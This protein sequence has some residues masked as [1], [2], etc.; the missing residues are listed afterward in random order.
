[1]RFLLEQNVVG[2]GEV[3]N[4]P[5][6]ASIIGNSSF[7]NIKDNHSCLIL[8][9][10]LF[11]TVFDIHDK[12]LGPFSHVNFFFRDW[13]VYHLILHSNFAVMFLTMNFVEQYQ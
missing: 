9:Y 7:D 4:S 8:V 10:S 2:I 12:C 3:R 5:D 13:F 6:M 1:M 11:Y